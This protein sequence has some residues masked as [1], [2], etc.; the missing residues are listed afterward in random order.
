M[1]NKII[2]EKKYGE[3]TYCPESTFFEIITYKILDELLEQRHM[4][5]YSTSCK[6]YYFLKKSNIQK[7]LNT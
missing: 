3:A 1:E 2:E 4:G 6:K 7:R 5:V